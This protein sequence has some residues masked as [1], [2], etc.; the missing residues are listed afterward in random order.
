VIPHFKELRRGIKLLN[1][2]AVW[3][4][5]NAKPQLAADSVISSFGIARSLVR[6]PLIISQL[7]RIAQ[8]AL[9]VST[10]QYVI[11]RAELTD[12]Q[13]A[14]LGEAVA[15]AEDPSAV[16]RGYVG[17]RCSGIS[18]FKGPPAVIA[19]LYGTDVPSV[20]FFELYNALGLGHRDGITY[21]D[22][23][24]EYLKTTQLPP[25]LRQEAA[26]VTN[27]KADEIPGSR[28]LLKIIVP[29]LARVTTLDLRNM[30]QLRTARV[31]L[32]IER[33]R[34]AAGE[35]PGEL[36]DLVPTYLDVVPSDPFDGNDLRYKKL[37]TGFVVYSIGEDGSDD[38]GKERPPKRKRGEE[39]VNYDVTFIIER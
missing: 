6:E 23:M 9:T 4:A 22:L 18:L 2:E 12:E 14:E 32:A 27:A 11:N 5:E 19:E 39:P 24:G 7:S 37:A 13:L 16:S 35:L 21:L 15:R 10:L 26:D 8:Q 29:A 38:G 34:L 31:G 20:P 33:Y 25:H 28:V 30:A 36:A 17:E 1:L 3:H